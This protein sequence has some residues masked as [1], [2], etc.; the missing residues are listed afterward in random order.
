MKGIY[1]E[2][3]YT[4]YKKKFKMSIMKNC[5]HLEV[6]V[7]YSSNLWAKFD[8]F[9]IQQTRNLLYQCIEVLF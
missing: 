1:C 2:P 9:S 6:N 4:F 5:S 3:M 8:E 7:L